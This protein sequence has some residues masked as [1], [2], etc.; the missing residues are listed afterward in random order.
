M[1]FNFIKLPQ[2]NTTIYPWCKVIIQLF[3]E[4]DDDDVPEDGDEPDEVTIFKK[5]DQKLPFKNKN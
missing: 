1:S 5:S 2:K 4:A 3:Q